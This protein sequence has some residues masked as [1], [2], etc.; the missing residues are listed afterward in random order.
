MNVIHFWD[1]D[2][3]LMDADSDVSWKLFMI[4]KG[5]ASEEDLASMSQFW[6]DY[7]AGCLDPVRFM[8][9]QLR[10]F[11]GKPPEEM[12]ILAQQHFEISIKP[13]CF[14]KARL[15]ISNTTQNGEINCIITACN[16]IVATPIINHFG[17]DEAIC[18]ELE[19]IDGVFTGRYLGAYCS[20]KEKIPH[21]EEF[22][23][24]H[25]TELKKA[26]YYGDSIADI[27][28]MEAIGHPVA[29]NPKAELLDWAQKKSWPI[30]D[31]R[32]MS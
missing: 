25:G 31:F 10:E 29:V 24:K 28:I 9:F 15:T 4:E 19:V 1:M 16:R 32:E 13:R 5:L 23:R 7:L 8:E 30:L 11:R 17:I 20:G 3:T 22:C 21:M 2:D 6:T 18:T 27:P 14:E 26:W 12:Q